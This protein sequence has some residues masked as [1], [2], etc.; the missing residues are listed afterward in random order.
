MNIEYTSHKGET[1]SVKT[2]VFEAQDEVPNAYR[3]VGYPVLGGE[4]M[5]V[6]F[7]GPDPEAVR[8]KIAEHFQRMAD[9]DAEKMNKVDG[10][11]KEGKALLA[12]QKEAA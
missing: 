8:T 10:R 6:A 3:C 2:V 7:R 5:P 1:V 9:F 4:F 11:T 12:A